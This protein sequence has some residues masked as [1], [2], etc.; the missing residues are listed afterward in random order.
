MTN[1]ELRVVV[2]R[3]L[4]IYDTNCDECEDCGA[5]MMCTAHSITSALAGRT[6]IDEHDV[7]EYGH[8]RPKVA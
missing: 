8:G 5:M 6:R 7:H 4:A 1:D 3:V 2:D